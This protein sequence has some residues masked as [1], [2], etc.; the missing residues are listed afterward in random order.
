MRKHDKVIEVFVQFYTLSCIEFSFTSIANQHIQ[1]SN[2]CLVNEIP[3]RNNERRLQIY[4]NFRLKFIPFK[5]SL[6]SYFHTYNP[7]CGTKDRLVYILKDD[8]HLLL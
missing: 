6:C 7:K 5:Q 4:R 8:N 1:K 2:W 3:R